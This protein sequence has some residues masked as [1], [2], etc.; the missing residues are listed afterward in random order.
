MMYNPVCQFIVC[1][2]T[3]L[4]WKK[5]FCKIL[6]LFI[7][8]I[9]HLKYMYRKFAIRSMWLC[10]SNT[11]P[12]QRVPSF[13]N[14]VWD[15]TGNILCLAYTTCKMIIQEV[16]VDLNYLISLCTYVKRCTWFTRYCFLPK[17]LKRILSQINTSTVLNIFLLKTII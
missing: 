1:F 13:T 7:T 12:A 16:K 10:Q 5:Y 15:H 8:W 2:F 14:R 4:T 3:G 17:T 6:M 11:E 9:Q